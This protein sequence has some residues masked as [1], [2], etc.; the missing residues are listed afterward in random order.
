MGSIYNSNLNNEKALIKG[1][2]EGNRI[3]QSQLYKIYAAQMM[4]VC[5][6][7]VKTREDAEDI[8]QDGF[9]QV[10]TCI[11]QFKFIGTLE[12]WIKKIFINC[13]LQKLRGKENNYL[14]VD[15][16]YVPE[17]HTISY[18]A[19]EEID[20]KILIKCIQVLP[21]ISRVVFNLYVF[22]GFKHKE[23]ARMLNI[24]EGTFCS[25]IHLL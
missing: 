3:Y 23:I 22:E 9:I 1:C 18:A 11:K 2:V 5:L 12:A 7:Y 14:F 15:I 10:F 6:R 20:M 24:S 17:L 13:A 19:T 21:L 4:G 25:F 16:E 8:L